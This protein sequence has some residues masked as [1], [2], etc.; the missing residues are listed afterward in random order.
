MLGLLG[1]DALMRKRLQSGAVLGVL[2]VAVPFV[3]I[4]TVLPSYSRPWINYWL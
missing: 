4:A 2:V 1:V 3:I